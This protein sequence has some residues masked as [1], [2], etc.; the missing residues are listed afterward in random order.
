[1]GTRQGEGADPAGGEMKI[2]FGCDHA[3]FAL[4]EALVRHAQAQGH[5]TVSVGAESEEPYDYP[6][7]A[8]LACEILLGGG[9][10]FGVLV[11]GSGIGICMRANRYH[12]IRAADCTSVEMAQLA[13]EHNHAN[14]LCLG[15]RITP[16]ETAV[17]IMDAFLAEPENQAERHKRRVAKIDG[18]V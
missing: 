2:V 11:C 14:V 8:D 12:G 10:E 5:E 7:A 4:R 17:L 13:R 1:E 6:D 16:E 18:N 9:A 15:Q 3:G